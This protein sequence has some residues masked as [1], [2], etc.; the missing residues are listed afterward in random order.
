MI[1]RMA[2][3]RPAQPEDGLQ[4]QTPYL[5]VRITYSRELNFVYNNVSTI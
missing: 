2:L 3:S 1:N 5:Y 4:C